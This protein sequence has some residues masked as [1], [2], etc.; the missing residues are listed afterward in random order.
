MFS[1]S[2]DDMAG[3]VIN[4]DS[5]ECVDATTNTWEYLQVRWTNIERSWLMLALPVQDNSWLSDSTASVTCDGDTASC[6]TGVTVSSTGGVANNYPDMLGTF[7]QDFSA[8]TDHPTYRKDDLTLYFL[9]V[10]AVSTAWS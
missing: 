1:Q 4:E 6:C 10:S 3:S 5:D 8:S 9:N 7:V 2:P